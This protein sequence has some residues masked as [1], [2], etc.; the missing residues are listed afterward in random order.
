MNKIPPC[1]G[2]VFLILNL[3]YSMK[4]NNSL[5]LC[6]VVVCHMAVV[7][8]KEEPGLLVDELNPIQVMGLLRSSSLKKKSFRSRPPNLAT[9]PRKYLGTLQSCRKWTSTFLLPWQPNLTAR[10]SK[11][12]IFHNEDSFSLCDPLHK[13]CKI[14][15]RNSE[16]ILRLDI[17]PQ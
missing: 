5:T 15:A 1:G 2:A 17:F 3:R 16:I 11:I 6:G 14:R 4:R 9:F 12:C 13:T 7:T 10:F 8:K